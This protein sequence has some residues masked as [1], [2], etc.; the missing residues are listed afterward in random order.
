M[1]TPTNGP[2][3]PPPSDPWASDRLPPPPTAGYRPV[4]VEQPA[5]IR[6]A[7]RLMLVGAA[8]SLVGTLVVLT[9]V[10]TIR[11][12]IEED[13]PSLTASEVDTVVDVTVGATVVAGVIGVG[14][15][16]W[17]AQKNGQ[18]R[19]WARVVATVLAVLN[20]VTTLVGVAGGGAAASLGF[21]LVSI[22]LAGA[23]LYLLYRPESTRFYE[24]RSRT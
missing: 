20:I 8:L 23:I 15:W 22:V 13:D 19:S 6:R 11:D 1:T 21:S 18:G 17:M 14:L 24:L 3:E 10:D 16:L 9:Q 4:P 2:F 12:T 5:S 7:V